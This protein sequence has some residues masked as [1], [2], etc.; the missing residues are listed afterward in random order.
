MKICRTML[1]GI[2]AFG[3]LALISRPALSQNGTS[4]APKSGTQ[5]ADS[6]KKS[7]SGSTQASTTK[8]SAADI[9]A[10]KTA[11]KVWVNT[12]TKVYHKD[13]KYYGNTKKGK[14]MAEADAKQ[15]GFR[16]AKGGE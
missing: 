2:L 10:A 13:G 16:A 5:S 12:E 3:M 8:P 9:Q 11:G 1:T 4:Q 14:F 15:A 7:D 6:S